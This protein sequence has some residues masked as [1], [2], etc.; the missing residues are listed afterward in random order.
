MY[1]NL[2]ETSRAK[3]CYYHYYYYYYYYYYNDNNNNNSHNNRTNDNDDGGHVCFA[4]PAERVERGG[5]ERNG[6]CSW[7]SGSWEN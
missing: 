5:R 4:D 2:S 1:E 7:E 3:Y 6:R